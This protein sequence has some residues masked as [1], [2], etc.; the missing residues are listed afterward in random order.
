MKDKI[1]GQ[2][3]ENNVHTLSRIISL[4]FKKPEYQQEINNGFLKKEIKE[5]DSVEEGSLDERM[6]IEK[7]VAFAQKM[8]VAL[9]KI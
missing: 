6:K 1:D 4:A 8:P 9:M 5:L 3:D 2:L 7:I